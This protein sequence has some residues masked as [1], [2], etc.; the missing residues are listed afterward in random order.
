MAWTRLC[1]RWAF[2]PSILQWL[3][4]RSG[5]GVG[6][7]RA[8]LVGSRIRRANPPRL[9]GISPRQDGRPSGIGGRRRIRPLLDVRQNAK[10]TVRFRWVR[11]RP[12][13]RVGSC[14]T[15][16]G[17]TMGC[18][19]TGKINEWR[20]DSYAVKSPTMRIK[21][22]P[23]IGKICRKNALEFKICRKII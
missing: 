10:K 18:W 19:N 15:E 7:W 6:S 9:V 14:R 22:A 17:M 8:F 1:S 23:K 5:A 13:G 2:A 16:N 20:M 11:T 21:Y 4:G 12:R 3:A